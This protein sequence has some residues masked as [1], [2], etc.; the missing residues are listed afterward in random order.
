[1]LGCSAAALAMM[2]AFL[3]AQ[4]PAPPAAG[5]PP[6]A[7]A[8]AEALTGGVP[9]VASG[10]RGAIATISETATRA[11]LQVM[12]QGG[13][14]VDAAVAAALML[15]V[16]DGGN[17]GLGGGCFILARGAYGKIV[18][19]D[20]RETAPAA[21]HARMFFRDGRP[22]PALSQIGALASGVP[23]AVA[24][25]HRLSE[26]LGTGRWSAAAAAAAD[27]AAEGFEIDPRY[28]AQIASVAESLS[29][30]E[31][32][33]ALF[34]DAEGRPRQAG[35]RMIQEDLAVTLRELASDGPDAFYRGRV[36]ELTAR[37]MQE[38]GGMITEEDFRHYRVRHRDPIETT[39][40]DHRILGFPPPSSGGIHVAQILE[41]LA[42][43]DLASM[44]RTDPIAYYHVVAEAMRLAFADRAVWLG[45]PAFADVPRGLL[46]P[47]YLQKRA[48]MIDP[49][50]RIPVV[51]AGGPPG[52]GIDLF[53]RL[54]RH[55][56]HLT[57]A[58]AAG[59]WVAITATVN[60]TFGSKVVVPGTG[61]ILNNEMDDFSIAPGVPNAFGLIGT[62][63]NA[64]AAGKRPLSS[65]SP[66]MV[67]RGDQPV[68]SCGAAGGPRII[69]AAAQ[70]VLRAVALDEPLATAVA[71]PRIH[72]QWRPNELWVEERLDPRI[73]EG[74]AGL[75]H[76]IRRSGGLGTAQAI[77]TAEFSGAEPKQ[78]TAVAEPRV[79]G[80]AAAR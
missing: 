76:T 71:A 25:Y 68:L 28:A 16:V 29:R 78:L 12:E 43:F 70:I 8:A 13:N 49:E 62:E 24:A 42:R 6:R 41:M 37:W 39:F 72:Q 26:E 40:A 5:A 45:D 59:N 33:R 22:D 80:H 75:G 10:A 19:I 34:F 2:P 73:V 15:A 23:G 77:S 54:P 60:T 67:L 55:T 69:T 74:L 79:A 53:G 18:A 21:A 30:F 52:V 20:G 47:E 3:R 50:N 46:D 56:T 14:A 11:G 44:Y 4:S 61:V 32:S 65:M 48:A 64:P 27:Q 9:H 57:A 17:S 38:N 63:A 7:A 66:T 31:G 58:D 1:M 35:D 36:A 51:T